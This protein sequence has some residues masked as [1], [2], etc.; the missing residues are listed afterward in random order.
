MRYV[1]RYGATFKRQGE[2]LTLIFNFTIPT[3]RGEAI[4]LTHEYT[5]ASYENPHYAQ[6]ASVYDLSGAEI[7]RL[8]GSD[9]EEVFDHFTDAGYDALFEASRIW[10][11]R[12]ATVEDDPHG[13]PEP[14]DLH[15]HEI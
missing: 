6:H 10:L 11:G 14:D 8:I 7:L 13:D 1:Q 5:V 4:E 15:L 2:P 9:A 3:N 12:V